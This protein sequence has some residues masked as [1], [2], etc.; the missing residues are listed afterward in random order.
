[1]S[2]IN[3]GLNFNGDFV[4]VFNN[5]VN[6]LLGDYEPVNPRRLRPFRKKTVEKVRNPFSSNEKLNRTDIENKFITLEEAKALTQ[7]KRDVIAEAEKKK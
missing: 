2:R 5:L 6:E 7:K 3:R 4:D 1:M